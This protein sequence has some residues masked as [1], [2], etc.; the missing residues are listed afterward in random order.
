[1]NFKIT[2]VQT[3]Q[4]RQILLPEKNI[5]QSS[6]NFVSGVTPKDAC[7]TWLR[8]GSIL[9]MKRPKYLYQSLRKFQTYFFNLRFG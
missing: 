4:I 8:S 1:M 3:N 9:I 7:R 2:S 5:S 6:Q